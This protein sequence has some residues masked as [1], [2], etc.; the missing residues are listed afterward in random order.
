MFGDRK[1]NMF[2]VNKKLGNFNREIEING[3]FRIKRRKFE[4]LKIIN[5]WVY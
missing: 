2:L 5:G 4:I 3:Y 1:G